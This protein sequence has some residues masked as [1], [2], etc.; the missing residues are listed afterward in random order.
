MSK[1]VFATVDEQINI[2]KDR[3]LIIIDE[4]KFREKLIRESYFFIAGYRHP[5]LARKDEYK[6]G[7]TEVELCALFN[8][9]RRFRNIMFKNLLIVENNLKSIFSYELSKRYG[10][11]EAEYL[12]INNYKN[13]PKDYAQVNDVLSKV[14]RQI[15]INGPKHTAT[16]HYLTNYNY[17]PLWILIKVLSFGIVAELFDILKIEDKKN[18]CKYYNVSVDNFTNY[19]PIL[20]NYRNLC[21]HEDIVYENKT[22][23]CIDETK[24]HKLFNIPIFEGEPAYGVNDL[25]ATIIILKQLLLKEE[26]FLMMNEIKYEFY[27]LEQSLT[28][29]T[30][31]DIYA[32]MGF[33]KNYMDIVEM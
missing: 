7:A 13:D 21:A 27:C 18:I 8:F 10:I 25:F 29:I 26:F 14:K 24:Y 4:E 30:I 22:D 6:K 12:N 23:R 2:L 16:A 1:K 11:K 3:G 9:D 31:K 28:S 33:P 32:K 5:F 20:A 17:I 15:R 19:L